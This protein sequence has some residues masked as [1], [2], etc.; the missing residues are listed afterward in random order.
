MHEIWLFFSHVKSLWRW[1]R[2]HQR[3]EILVCSFQYIS[4]GEIFHEFR[5]QNL[6]FLGYTGLL[7]FSNVVYIKMLH[8]RFRDN[9]KGNVIWYHKSD[10]IFIW[11]ALSN[12]LPQ[13][14]LLLQTLQ[15]WVRHLV[16]IFFPLQIKCAKYLREGS[17]NQMIQ[18]YVQAKCSAVQHK[19]FWVT[20]YTSMSLKAI[21]KTRIILHGISQKKCNMVNSESH[22][23]QM[24]RWLS[25]FFINDDISV[26]S[27]H[28]E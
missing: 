8:D 4:V 18:G 26:G 27:S 2:K 23:F 25:S 5:C 6:S 20:T 21:N 14:T 16:C 28:T 24:C 13:K 15:P 7:T 3:R 10:W 1:W 17:V 9:N 12:I 22:Q 19:F 11:K